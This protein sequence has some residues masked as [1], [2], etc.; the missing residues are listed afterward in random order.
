MRRRLQQQQ[1][2]GEKERGRF[3]LDFRTLLAYA[4][5][6]PH[7]I[8]RI[9]HDPAD[10]DS[11]SPD[12]ARGLGFARD[13]KGVALGLIVLVDALSSDGKSVYEVRPAAEIART[14]AL[15]YGAIAADELARHLRGL[16]VAARALEAGD[17]AKAGL[18]P[19]C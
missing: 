13:E 2:R 16:D 19:C 12:P 10:D 14:L 7:R 5:T 6:H 8:E 18:P 17:L 9:A 4:K 3:V 11:V 15:A 1:S